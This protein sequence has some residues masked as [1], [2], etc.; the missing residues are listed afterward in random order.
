MDEPDRN[1]RVIAR[2]LGAIL[3]S[4]GVLIVAGINQ[5]GGRVT[6]TGTTTPPGPRP[7]PPAA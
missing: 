3:V 5:G 6:T 1:W 2:V 7:S 4:A